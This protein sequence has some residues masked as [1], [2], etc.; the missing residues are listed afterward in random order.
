MVDFTE[1]I[2]QAIDSFL[3]DILTFDTF[4]IELYVTENNPKTLN[5]LV[6]RLKACYK[7]NPDVDPYK[8]A[9]GLMPSQAASC[10]D[11]KQLY[12]N[13]HFC[14][15]DKFA[16]LTNG[17]GI[18]RHIVFLDDAFK[19][20]HPEMPVGKKSGSPDGDKWVCTKVHV[21]NGAWAYDCPEPCNTAKKRRT[22]Y[23]YDNIDFRMFPG[24]QRGS[25]EWD[26]SIR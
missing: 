18:V 13:G 22:A 10:P 8:M 9:Y 12:V 24:I 17:L 11:T 14:Y 7:D 5:S 25:D 23:T 15:A 20:A 3:A 2:C 4:G 16:I 21:V 1:P 26:P 19:E 6:R